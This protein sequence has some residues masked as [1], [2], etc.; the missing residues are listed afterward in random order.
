MSEKVRLRCAHFG[1]PL[2]F[3]VRVLNHIQRGLLTMLNV[4]RSPSASAAPGRNTYNVP[5]LALVAGW[6][7][8]FGAAFEARLVA[9][10]SATANAQIIDSV[11][12]YASV[13]GSERAIRG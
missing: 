13:D 5:R 12:T 9:G 4:S 8:I 10:S 3:P 2:S 1:Q 7:Q 11:A 6:P